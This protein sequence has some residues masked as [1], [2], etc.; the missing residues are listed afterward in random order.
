MTEGQAVSPEPNK[1]PQSGPI[2]PR[3]PWYRKLGWQIIIVMVVTM[4]T[5]AVLSWSPWSTVRV[6]DGSDPLADNLREVQ[7]L[8][9][10]ENKR[11]ISSGRPWVSIAVMLPIRT[12][13]EARNKPEDAL[14]HIQGAYLAQ[15]WSNHPNGDD[16]FG[17]NAPL[18]RILIADTGHEGQE[19]RDTVAQLGEMAKPGNNERLVAVA[20]LGLSTDAT[21]QAV[22]ALANKGISMVGSVITATG[23]AATGLFRVAPTNSDEAA[24]M[25]NY[26]ED[27]QEW[28]SASAT[29]PYK[30]YLVQDR[31]G[32]D[33]YVQDLGNQYRRVFPNDGAHI[34]P[35]AQGDY[36]SQKEGAGNAI[37]AQIATICSFRPKVVFFAGRS[38]GLRTFL[39]ALSAR[40]CSDTRI[41]VVTGDGA[42]NLNDPADTASLWVDGA[43]LNVFY[44]ALASPETWQNH[45]TAVS[46]DTVHRF[47]QCANCFSALFSEPFGEGDAI[48]SHDA[49][50]TAI[51]AAKNVASQQNPQPTADAIINGLYQINATNPVPGASGW[52]YFQR[53]GG[54]PDGVP[55]N[56]AVPI[57][58]LH[59]NGT[60]SQEDLSS[61]SGTPPAGPELPY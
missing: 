3:R 18:I 55:Y 40:Y 42:N 36:N 19:W 11:V 27:T 20:G 37:A 22:N 9:L 16:K 44:T 33:I 60:A 47:G 10:D 61:R 6:T 46:R 58:Q 13:D 43:N 52:I 38:D 35:Q 15:Y 29:D 54:I 31:A 57:M 53:E 34:L 26:L 28:K 8:I 56:K 21:Q 48:M 2:N 1:L 17:D 7:G 4:L 39:R 41:T 12:T 23:L 51:T 45:P 49:V 32:D 14:R 30:A 5:A 50:L 59:S 24:A 25:I